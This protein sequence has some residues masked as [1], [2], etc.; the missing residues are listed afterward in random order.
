VIGI[1]V[2]ERVILKDDRT[3]ECRDRWWD[4]WR[5]NYADMQLSR[6]G[7]MMMRLVMGQTGR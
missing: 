4:S 1:V 3:P 2:R 7:L 6:A 5:G